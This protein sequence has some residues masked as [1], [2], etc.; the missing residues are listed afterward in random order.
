MYILVN[1]HSLINFVRDMFYLQSG[2]IGLMPQEEAAINRALHESLLQEKKKSPARHK[3]QATSSRS[4]SETS[5]SYNAHSGDRDDHT[6]KVE[7]PK[8]MECDRFNESSTSKSPTKRR[9]R[10]HS[11]TSPSHSLDYSS[12]SKSSS[13]TNGGAFRGNSSSSLSSPRSVE[14][15]LKLVLSTSSWSRSSSSSWSPTPEPIVS[16]KSGKGVTQ[17][18]NKVQLLPKM[19]KTVESKVKGKRGRPRKYPLK[20][21]VTLSKS[22]VKGNKVGTVAP[23]TGKAPKTY[24]KAALQFHGA[25]LSKKK[26]QNKT[27]KL[28]QQKSKPKKSHE[29]VCVSQRSTEL[30]VPPLSPEAA[31]V[32]HDHCYSGGAMSHASTAVEDE[33]TTSSDTKCRSGV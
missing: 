6:V 4:V 2:L 27:G 7:N 22:I 15:S 24:T 17:K 13:P 12:E 18:S 16:N 8:V 1:G 19:K 20:G 28:Q 32:L 30:D 3:Q 14:S 31:L 11:P 33:T 26:Q 23:K 25:L 10:L 21:S 29:H 5:T 9:R